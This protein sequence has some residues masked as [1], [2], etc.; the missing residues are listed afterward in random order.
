MS[1]E[2]RQRKILVI[3]SSPHSREIMAVQWYD[4]G[5]P[6]LNIADYDVVIVNVSGVSL[7]YSHLVARAIPIR[8]CFTRLLESKGELFIISEPGPANYWWSPIQ[9]HFVKEA[10]DTIEVQ[11]E[12]VGHLARYLGM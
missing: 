1:S 11:G 9:F 3:G 5:L 12:N 6:T 10:G 4:Y 2:A 8:A 7:D